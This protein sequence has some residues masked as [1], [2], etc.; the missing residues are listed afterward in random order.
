[1]KRAILVVLG[2]GLLAALI[3]GANRYWKR[4][5]GEQ[6]D[7][8]VLYGHVE[9]REA[10]LSFIESELVE[11]V[12]VQEGQAV[13]AGQVLARLRVERLAAV[14]AEVL[15]RWQ[16]QEQALRRLE[17]GTR[18]AV[19]AQARAVLAAS[20]VRLHNAHRESERIE[21][22][23]VQGASTEK[24]LDQA[25][26]QW[27]LAQADLLVQKEALALAE[28]GPR[29]EDIEQARAGLRA[30]QAQVDLLDRRLGDLVLRAPQ[31]GVVQS[32]LV[33]KG[34]LASTGRP[35][36]TLALTDPKWIRTYLPEPELGKVKPGQRAWV[37]TDTWPETKFEAWVGHVSSTAEFTPKSVETPDLRTSLVYELRLWVD[38]GGNRLR[39]GM[40]VTV[41]LDPDAPMRTF[42]GKP[43]VPG[44]NP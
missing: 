10:Q 11:E 39:L 2:L 9:I 8:L 5:A 29:Q 34:E 1:M 28:E 3:V 35:A 23:A 27:E 16:G 20:Q 44:S 26:A 25:K 41:Q 4:S 15:A 18:P 7:G 24:E 40:P 6:A 12:L 43:E 30:L 37:L 22:S 38:D 13:Q 14:R 19:L 21:R 36:F 42:D 31:A 17:N 32:R 33:E